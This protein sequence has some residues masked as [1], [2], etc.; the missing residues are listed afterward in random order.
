[1]NTPVIAILWLHRTLTRADVTAGAD[2]EVLEAVNLA[3]PGGKLLVPGV[4]VV[5]AGAERRRSSLAS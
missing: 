2:A 1:L 4:M 5:A 3:L